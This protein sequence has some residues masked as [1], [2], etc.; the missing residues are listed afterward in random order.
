MKVED[1]SRVDVFLRAWETIEKDNTIPLEEREAILKLIKVL[2][3]AAESSPYP[4]EKNNQ[5]KTFTQEIISKHALLTLVKQQAD[6]LDALKS[7]S[8][9]LTSSLDLQ[10]VLDAVVTEAMRLVKNARATHIFLYSHDKLEFGSSLT[11]ENVRNKPLSMPRVD[12]LTNSVVQHG[13]QIIIED[14]AVHP[15]YKNIPY[16][17][18]GSIVGI[19]LKFKNSIVGVMNL[20]RSTTG[21]FSSAELRLI[22]LLADQA[23]VAIYNASL[24][25][26][27]T[28]LAY[29]DSV[30]GLPNRRALDERLQDEMR[31]A[32]QT[33]SMFSIVMMDLDGF[34]GVNDV[35]GHAVGDE[36]LH[37]LFNYLSENMRATDFLARYG[38]DE[39]TLVMRDGNLAATE[40]VTFKILELMKEYKFE[41]PGKTEILLGIS[42]GIAIYPIHARTAGDLLRAADMALYQAKKRNR[43]SFVI[44]NGETGPLNP[45]TLSSV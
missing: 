19:P 1:R 24:H 15:F 2:V 18:F 11:A 40:A 3:E 37:S 14:I 25:K 7:L 32:K 31:Y 33:N 21:G 27:V 45:I 10:T 8:L 9:N 38:G 23:A 34:K 35:Y 6:E 41:Y 28:D 43:G 17:W 30:T 36:V 39:L 5:V 29:T 44:A 12:G 42:A 16:G 4:R 13:E 26:K 22:G 20:S